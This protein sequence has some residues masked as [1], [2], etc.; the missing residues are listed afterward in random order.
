ML[1]FVQEGGVL[2]VA[3][4]PPVGG[5]AHDD[6]EDAFDGKDPAIASSDSQLCVPRDSMRVREIAYAQ[7][8]RPPPL[9]WPIPQ[10]RIPPS[11]PA[12]AAPPKKTPTRQ[13]RSLRL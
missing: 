1:P 11:A 13:C 4:D 6:G 10:A 8:G 3:G 7:L 12:K 9:M 2:R 5:H